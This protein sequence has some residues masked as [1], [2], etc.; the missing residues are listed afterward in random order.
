MIDSLI[1]CPRCHSPLELE[2][3]GEYGCNNCF[4][5]YGFEEGILDLYYSPLPDFDGLQPYMWSDFYFLE[6]L[7]NKIV[8]PGMVI[9]EI[10]SGANYVVPAILYRCNLKL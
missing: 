4:I 3:N 7:L 5:L 10:C 2:E 1:A 6:N 9:T 8:K